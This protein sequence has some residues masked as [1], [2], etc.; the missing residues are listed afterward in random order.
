MLRNT[1]CFSYE[2]R[3]KPPP[4]SGLVNQ[5]STCYLNAVIQVLYHLPAFRYSIYSI[6][7]PEK[8]SITLALRNIFSQLNCSYSFISTKDLTDAFGWEDKEAYIQQD[9]HEMMQKLFQ[10]L[11]RVCK[12]T[13]QENFIRDLFYG[14]ITYITRTV[15]GVDHTTYHKEGFYDIEL[16]VKDKNSIYDS[17]DQWIQP[18]R[19]ENVSLEIEKGKPSSVHVVERKQFF[20]RLPPV[21]LV[22]PNRVCF[23]TETCE[24]LMLENKWTFSN[25]LNLESYIFSEGGDNV[26]DVKNLGTKYELRSVIIHQGGAHSGHYLSYVHI[27]EE[28][29]C[30]NDNSVSRVN[31]KIVMQAAYGGKRGY[32][33]GFSNE[34]ASLLMYVNKKKSDEILKEKPIPKH[35]KDVAE[36]INELNKRKWDEAYTKKEYYYLKDGE[37]LIHV[38]DGYANRGLKSSL[39]SSLCTSSIQDLYNTIAA[40]INQTADKFRIW[41]YP[42]IPIMKS[43]CGI[44]K[45]ITSI[46]FFFFVESLPKPKE[47]IEALSKDYFFAPV[48]LVYEDTLRFY[49]IVHSREELK[50]LMM[51][52]KEKMKCFMCTFPPTVYEVS[53]D[54]VLI[55]SNLILCPESVSN[56][57]L[58]YILQRLLYNEVHLFLLENKN[59]NSWKP[60][61]SF[62]LDNNT[63]Y[64]DLQ[65]EAFRLLSL[66]GLHLPPS[67]EYIGFHSQISSDSAVPSLSI[68]PPISDNGCTSTLGSILAHQNEMGCLYVQILPLPLSLLDVLRVVIFNVGGGFRPLV[69]IEKKNYTL[70][71]LFRI[72]LDQYGSYLSPEL[73]QRITRS[74]QEN[75]PA[76]RLLS[77]E[78]MLHLN[79]QVNNEERIPL[80]PGYYI[81]DVLVEVKEGFSLIDVLFCS[82]RKKEDYF[83]FPTNIPISNTYEETGE[84]IARRVAD[85]IK[86][87]EEVADITLW[88]VAI[89]EQK[90]FYH[91]IGSKD[92]LKSVIKRISSEVECFVID[93]PRSFSLDGVENSHQKSEQSIVIRETS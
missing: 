9:V 64:E 12:N 53:V 26:K 86:A 2:E 20:S 81:I 68:A 29:I 32:L 55:G 38:L 70:G 27:G 39:F 93:R 28:W 88:I 3:E 50:E 49:G 52:N 69:F 51:E 92:S 80:T 78:E 90:G 72:T 66:A 85:K 79:V 8:H 21:L 34:R 33:S 17:L 62:Q 89:R 45:D 35:L 6:E 76:L 31:E 48:R 42:E 87:T 46:K 41:V 10:I 75:I 15:D 11:E 5:G 44:L 43:G 60:F 77:Y 1:Y 54:E 61:G 74:L 19:M 36:N 71:E 56:K 14:E 18:E 47:E 59:A 65:K 57:S 82:R 73:V 63:S 37:R 83:G 58:L 16:S 24:V 4:Y 25:S 67:P 23:S 84:E 30:F 40:E 7:E 22:H 91:T 13:P